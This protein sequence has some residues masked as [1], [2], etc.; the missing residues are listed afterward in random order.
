MAGRPTSQLQ[1]HR[2]QMGGQACAE[3][4]HLTW[5][6]TWKK[7]SDAPSNSKYHVPLTILSVPI[8]PWMFFG[9]NIYVDNENFV[10]CVDKISCWVPGRFLYVQVLVW[11]VLASDFLPS[12]LL[13]SLLTSLPPSIHPFSHPSIH[14]HCPKVLWGCKHMKCH[15]GSKS[16]TQIMMTQ[17]RKW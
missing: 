15:R 1:A 8:S 14:N 11:H 16:C 3:I 10:Y 5:A 4:V 2:S 12:S 17:D 13:P 6:A 9:W 7:R